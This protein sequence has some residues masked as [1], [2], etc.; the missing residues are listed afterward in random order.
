MNFSSGGNRIFNGVEG[1][2][3]LNNEWKL[4]MDAIFCNFFAVLNYFSSTYIII[5]KVL[6]C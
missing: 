3:V 1:E 4:G 5:S 6:N 2:R